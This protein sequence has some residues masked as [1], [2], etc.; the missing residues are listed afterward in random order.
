MK[1]KRKFLNAF[2]SV[3]LCVSMLFTSS[4]IPTLAAGYTTNGEVTDEKTDDSSVVVYFTLSDNGLLTHGNDDNYTT[5]ARIPMTVSWFDLNDYGLGDFSKC[6]ENGNVIEKPTVLHA[7]I[8][9][10]EL[11]YCPDET[12][13]EIGSDALTISGSA[14][15]MYMTNFWGHDENLMYY[16]NHAYPL[17]SEGWGATADWIL[18][19]GRASC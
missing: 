9:A 3:M 10:L 4:G 5:L 14:G 2:L 18:Q 13:L 16:V 15:S 7:I 6:D 1:K 8:H 19:I 11:Y 12:P 17:M